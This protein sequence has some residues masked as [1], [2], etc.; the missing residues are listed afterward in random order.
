VLVAFGGYKLLR[1]TKYVS[2]GNIP[3]AQALEEAQNDPDNV[4]IIKGKW[5]ERWNFLW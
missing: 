2:L 1:R 5:W 4:P 3:I